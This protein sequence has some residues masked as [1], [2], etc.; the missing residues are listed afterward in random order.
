MESQ[1]LEVRLRTD[2][3]KNKVK[4]LKRKGKNVP[5]VLYG[6]E[7][8]PL[9][10]TIELRPYKK[11]LHGP[12]GRNTILTLKIKDASDKPV[13]EIPALSYQFETDSLTDEIIHV[14]F[15]RI[16]PKKPL[17]IEAPIKIKGLAPG[18][19]T[20]GILVQKMRTLKIQTL[21]ADVPPY[22]E[23]DVSGLELGKGIHVGDLTKNPKITLLRKETD[24]IVHVEIP[25]GTA[26]EETAAPTAEA[27]P[28]TA[29]VATPAAASG[30]PAKAS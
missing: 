28:E 24:L 16:D 19:K 26:E 18:V 23:I 13:S 17:T 21:P 8:E 29:T 7:K 9:P 1:I 10:L 11:I 20:G 27:S 14:D 25:R 4:K 12:F 15:L 22:I 6:E 3:K 30:T 5:A 2:L